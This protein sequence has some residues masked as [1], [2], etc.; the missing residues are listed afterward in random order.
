MKDIFTCR[1]KIKYIYLNTNSTERGKNKN[2]NQL[3]CIQNINF[4][5]KKC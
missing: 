4:E 5:W 3:K 2:I 1:N